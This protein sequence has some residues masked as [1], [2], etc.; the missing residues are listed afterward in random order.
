MNASKKYF[1]ILFC[2]LFITL[3][4]P[5]K[6]TAQAEFLETYQPT[7]LPDSPLYFLKT[8]WENIQLFFTFKEQAKADLYLKLANKRLIEAQKLTEKGKIELAQKI[9]NKFQE[10][11]EK[12][13]SK[14]EALKETDKKEIL[15]EKL[16]ENLSRQQAVLEKVYDKVAVEAKEAILQAQLK[17]RQGLENAILRIQGAH[18]LEEFKEKLKRERQERSLQKQKEF[19]ETQKQ[20]QYQ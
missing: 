11:M 17:S 10:R 9:L 14:L 5:V 2:L 19:Q 4:L 1:M 20:I 3:V 15:I 6:T 12:A 13:I 8:W 16:K 18:K 7:L